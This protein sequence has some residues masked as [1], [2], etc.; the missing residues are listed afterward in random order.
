MFI[1]RTKIH[2]KGGN[3]GNG[4][5]SFHRE[6]NVTNGGPDGGDGGYGG[7][8]IFVGDTSLNTLIDF[9]Y[10]RTYKAQP[11]E[12][13]SKKNCSG[14]KGENLIIKCPVGTIILEAESGKIIADIS[15]PDKP[16]TIIKGG[17]GGKGNQHFATSTRQAPRYAQRGQLSKELDVILELKLIADVGLIGFPNV[18]KSSLLKSATN[19]NPKIANYHF[20]TLSPNLGVVRG[21]W[22]N[23]FVMADIP[24]IIEGAHEGA[25]LGHEFLRHVERTKVLIH[26][27]D[28]ASIEGDDPIE[29]FEKL[30]NELREYSEKLLERPQIVAANKTD[31]MGDDSEELNRIIKKL[32]EMGYEVFPVSAAT[33]AGIEELITC[34]A[35]L[36]K[37]VPDVVFDQEFDPYEEVPEDHKVFEVIKHDDDYF[38][39]VGKGVEKMFGYTNIDTEKGMAFFQNYIRENGIVAE[40]ENQGAKDGDT[41]R[42]YDLEFEYFK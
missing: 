18:G 41:V 34:A 10:K 37:D 30:N 6:K 19:A 16:V 40:L 29:K 35:K 2:I 20:T 22:G 38:E 39:V 11:G 21:N 7:S 13:G 15:S 3:G 31:L 28:A 4:C 33:G 42:I 32:N 9:R 5:V 17:R 27:I 36:L 25:G 8:I 26:V 12:D 1:D 24:G 14:K 23:D